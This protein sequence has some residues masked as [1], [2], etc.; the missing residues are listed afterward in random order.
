MIRYMPQHLP[1]D[2]DLI[3]I[4]SLISAQSRP[5]TSKHSTQCRQ[6]KA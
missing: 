2:V 6:K 3:V 1:Q 5:L 4:E